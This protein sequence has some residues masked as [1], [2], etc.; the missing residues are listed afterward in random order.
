MQEDDIIGSL[1]PSIE[2]SYGATNIQV[3][4]GIEHVRMAVHLEAVE[5]PEEF[6]ETL[7]HQFFGL[8]TVLGIPVT[9]THRVLVEEVV[10]LFL[11][12]PVVVRTPQ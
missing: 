3:L 12:S 6:H 7:V 8:L 9:Y 5:V 11:G 10:K 2:T 1:T 4:D